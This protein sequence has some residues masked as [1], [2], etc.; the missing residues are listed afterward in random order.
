MKNRTALSGKI[1]PLIMDEY[2]HS[3][4]ALLLYIWQAAPAL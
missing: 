1:D 3:L 2:S 4:Q